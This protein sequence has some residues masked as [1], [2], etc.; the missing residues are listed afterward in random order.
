MVIEQENYYQT[1]NVAQNATSEEIRAAYELA[2]QTYMSD[3]LATYSLYSEEENDEILRKITHAYMTLIDPVSR[4]FYDQSLSKKTPQSSVET[5]RFREKGSLANN[6]LPFRFQD[7]NPSDAS[8][9]DKEKI[10]HAE[11]DGVNQQEIQSEP[12]SPNEKKSME[13][14]NSPRLETSSNSKAIS[15]LLAEHLEERADIR[16]SIA[17]KNKET[18]EKV[19]PVIASVEVYNGNT[20]QQI[21][22]MKSITIEEMAHETCVR[23]LYLSA[24]ENED[25]VKL[26]KAPVYL[27]SFVNAYARCLELPSAKVVEDYLNLFQKNS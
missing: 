27:K 8:E 18:N 26:P 1:L 7:L 17:Q 10:A 20:L 6:N 5:D 3:S 14:Q 2:T 15:E 13:N 21:R 4:A 24:I 23:Q 19:Q 25:F 12:S 9:K 22:E 11:T 16:K